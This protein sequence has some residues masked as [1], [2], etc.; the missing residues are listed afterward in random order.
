MPLKQ[1]YRWR[2]YHIKGM[3]A[4][5]L[6]TVSA[7]DEGEAIKKAIVELEVKEPQKQKRLIA[8]RQG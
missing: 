2:I 8:L 1:D 3:P 4:Q 5:F 7:R 6:R